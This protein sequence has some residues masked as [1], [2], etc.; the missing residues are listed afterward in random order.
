MA[1]FSNGEVLREDITMTIGYSNTIS[2]IEETVYTVE[3]GTRVTMQLL[4][5]RLYGLGPSSGNAGFTM[6]IKIKKFID[7]FG[8]GAGNA[9]DSEK[10]LITGTSAT[11]AEYEG[12][13][14]YYS[15]GGRSTF[16]ATYSSDYNLPI[17][18]AAGDR[19]V[20]DLIDASQNIN[21]NYFGKLNLKK[22]SLFS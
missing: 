10:I 5:I 3:S 15:Y 13:V 18:L 22:Y 11:A 7:P 6:R 17:E 20:F 8:T 21:I 14:L 9:P 19:V 4:D 12:E 2:A 16:S 1:T